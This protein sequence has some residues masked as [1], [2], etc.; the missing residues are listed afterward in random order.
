MPIVR[1]ILVL[2]IVGGLAALAV[3]NGSA[4]VA[5]VFLGMTTPTLPLAVWLLGAI[6]A[7]VVTTLTLNLLFSL[8]NYWAVRQIRPRSSPRR[9][10]PSKSPS[11][12]PFRP[13]AAKSDDDAA[14]QNWEGYED[15][16]R[17]RPA[18][19][20]PRSENPRTEGPRTEGPRTENPRAEDRRTE[21]PRPENVR[22]T[23]ADLDDWDFMADDD[24]DAVRPPSSGPARPAEPPPKATPAGFGTS[25]RPLQ[26]TKSATVAD[27][28]KLVVDAD[29][30]VIIPPYKPSP[31]PEGP[32]TD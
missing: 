28:S 24:W 12:R 11:G 21:E 13:A 31:P 9:P 14:W 4:A 17:S 15:P 1:L 6:A 19:P 29:Y 27:K 22:P 30:R 2:G 3:S 5:L 10:G 25:D 26:D 20:V 7:G 23:E 18:V 32:E 8:S 16:Q